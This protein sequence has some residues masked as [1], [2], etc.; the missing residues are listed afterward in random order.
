MSLD[1]ED[2]QRGNMIN[3]QTNIPD[4]LITHIFTFLNGRDL[5][6]IHLC[7]KFC[8]I[9]YNDSTLVENQIFSMYVHNVLLKVFSRKHAL[10]FDEHKN[11]R[12]LGINDPTQIMT[13]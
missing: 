12:Y 6:K 5:T 13:I 10:M 1:K 9:F 2:K 4:D 8:Q 3:L 11:V 7:R